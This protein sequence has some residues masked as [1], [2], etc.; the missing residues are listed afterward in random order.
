LGYLQ[1]R[2]HFTQLDLEQKI[3]EAEENKFEEILEEAK[4]PSISDSDKKKL[5]SAIISIQ[6]NLLEKSQ[7]NVENII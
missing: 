5:E 6:K 7:Q 2:L 4:N 3:Q 1:A